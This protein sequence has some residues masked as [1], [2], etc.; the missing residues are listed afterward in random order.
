MQNILSYYYNLYPNSVD[1][2]DSNYYFEY[3]GTSYVLKIYDRPE[4]DIDSLYDLNKKMILTDK[5]ILNKDNNAITN[6]NNKKYVLLEKVFNTD[7]VSLKDIC[8]LNNT[9]VNIECSNNLSRMNWVNLWESKNDYIESQ[10]KEIDKKYNNLTK[11]VNYYIG[12]A[13]NAC[14]YTKKALQVPGVSLSSVCH[15]RIGDDIYDPLDFIYDYRVRDAV[16]Y[17]KM[18]FFN[19]KDSIKLVEEYFNNNYISYKEA[20]LFYARL[21]YPSYFFDTYEDIINKNLDES[22]IN[23][24]V[25]KAGEY[26]SFLSYTEDYISS[27]YNM[28]IPKINW[29][30][31]ED[32]SLL[33]Y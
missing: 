32:L 2:K 3:N 30:K 14:L 18:S 33:Q 23:N 24:I 20:L 22:L 29:L 4:S 31:K 10:L 11:Y 9:S 19:N 26:E 1:E 5:I 12:L 16:E 6:I 25:L 15:K 17:I 8:Y 27:L 21:L 13:E 28:Y 7:N